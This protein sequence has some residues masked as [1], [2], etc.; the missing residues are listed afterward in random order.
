MPLR[1]GGIATRV[2]SGGFIIA[3]DKVGDAGP[4]RK[5]LEAHGCVVDNDS[6]VFSVPQKPVGDTYIDTVDRIQLGAPFLKD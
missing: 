1:E 4:Y 2:T 3:A 6:A 5:V